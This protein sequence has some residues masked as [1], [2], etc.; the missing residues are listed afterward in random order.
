MQGA[1]RAAARIGRAQ[2]LTPLAWRLID[3]ALSTTTTSD[4]VKRVA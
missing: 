3:A 2:Q 4:G 1:Q